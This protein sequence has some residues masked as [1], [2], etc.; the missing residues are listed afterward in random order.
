MGVWGWIG[1]A[2]AL[3]L[4]LSILV[5]K[6]FAGRKSPAERQA[7]DAAQVQYLAAWRRG[8]R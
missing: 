1:V 2:A 3:S 5:G 8:E 7:E 6:M 4:L